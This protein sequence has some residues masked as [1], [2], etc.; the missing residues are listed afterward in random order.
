LTSNDIKLMYSMQDIL[1][2]YGMQMDRKGFI[3]CPFHQEKSNSM[4]IYNSSYYCFGCGKGGDIFTFVQEMDGLTFKEAF[5]ELGGEYKS[6]FS[7]YMKIDKAKHNRQKLEKKREQLK[8]EIDLNNSLISVY[9][10]WRD[11]AT[12]MSQTWIDC[13]NRLQYQLYKHE[14]LEGRW[15]E[16]GFK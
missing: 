10:N 14:I 8:Q 3:N 2:R 9:R 13:T 12:P 15:S 16:I 4:K 1:V 11:K 5:R 6:D 7:T